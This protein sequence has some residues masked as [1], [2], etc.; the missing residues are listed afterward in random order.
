[1]NS[2]CIAMWDPINDVVDT[3]N[4]HFL[5]HN[6]KLSVALCTQGIHSRNSCNRVKHVTA[7]NHLT[8]PTLYYAATTDWQLCCSWPCFVDADGEG[9]SKE[10]CECAS[11][12]RSIPQ[13]SRT[14]LTLSVT[15]DTCTWECPFDYLLSEVHRLQYKP[16]P[17]VR[18]DL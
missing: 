16:I 1:M 6:M 3:W 7:H 12:A 17:G 9:K 18:L 14:C 11:S 8:P 5:V 10:V 2:F 4:L 15:S 13:P